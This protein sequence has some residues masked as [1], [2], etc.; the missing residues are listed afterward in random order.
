MTPIDKCNLMFSLNNNP[1]CNIKD[2]SKSK[3]IIHTEQGLFSKDREV[4]IL[5]SDTHFAFLDE[6]EVYGHI[7]RYINEIWCACLVLSHKSL[8]KQL[9][10]NEFLYE[11]NKQIINIGNWSPM[12]SISSND[13]FI[14][15]ESYE[16]AIN[17]MI[18]MIK[19][20]SIENNIPR[21]PSPEEEMAGIERV[22]DGDCDF[23]LLNLY[24]INLTYS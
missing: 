19:N 12:N 17:E 22:Q 11:Y 15:C 18:K 8:N 6:Y 2:I 24:G 10:K 4:L 1:S 13:V 5:L 3:R 20:Y 7:V 9:G 21:S 23:R 14:E 16:E